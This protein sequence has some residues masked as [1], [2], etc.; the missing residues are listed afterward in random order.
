MSVLAA[1]MLLIL[2]WLV[3]C[4]YILTQ[5]TKRKLS[6]WILLVSL[7]AIIVVFLLDAFLLLVDI[8]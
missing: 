8:G 1:A 3:A 4:F 6:P 2:S 5:I 7:V